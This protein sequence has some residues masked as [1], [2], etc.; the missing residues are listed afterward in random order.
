MLT[1]HSSTHHDDHALHQLQVLSKILKAGGDPLRLEILRV[2][3]K[4]SFGV[5]ELCQIFQIKQS[6]MSHHLKVLA[7]AGLVAS[8]KEGNSVFYFRPELQQEGLPSPLTGA[9][10][11]CLDE[12]PIRAEIAH[13]MKDAF[14]R[15]AEVSQKFFSEN[16]SHAAEQQDLIAGLNV[17]GTHVEQFLAHQLAKQNQTRFAHT[18]EIGP[19]NGEFLPVLS[20]LSEHVVALD[21]NKEMLQLAENVAQK[22]GLTNVSFALDDTRFCQNHRP[23]FHCAVINMVL[24]HTPS[25]Q[26]IF[27]DV[28]QCLASGGVLVIADLCQHDQDWTRTTCGDMWLGFAPESLT[29]WALT[30]GL[31]E[32][33][34]K[35]FALR[36]GFQ[37]QIREF[38]K[39]H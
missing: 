15:R 10:F 16:A 29:Q 36:N 19:G 33:H 23:L 21:N 25:P 28:S 20:H 24:H 14:A 1:L 35:Y 31:E 5:L 11:S 18:L 3:E 4:D 30:S 37:I 2:L 22:Q 34:S 6:G 39:P 27:E 32:G 38:I 26:C 8:R 12:S 9:L 17:Y 13:A 7:Q